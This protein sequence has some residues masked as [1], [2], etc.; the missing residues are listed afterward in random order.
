LVLLYLSSLVEVNLLGSIAF[1]TEV[2][3]SRVEVTCKSLSSQDASS[4][5]DLI[6][7]VR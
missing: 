1:H 4:F 6:P 5:K 7:N 3:G 2:Q